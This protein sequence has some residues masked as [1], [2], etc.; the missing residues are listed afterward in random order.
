MLHRRRRGSSLVFSFAAAR[1]LLLFV[2]VCL[3]LQS[4]SADDAPDLTTR[5]S[6]VDTPSPPPAVRGD[7]EPAAVDDPHHKVY[8]RLLERGATADE[9]TSVRGLH[10]T[11]R[12]L[13]AQE[14]LHLRAQRQSQENRDEKSVEEEEG[15]KAAGGGLSPLHAQRKRDAVHA[16]REILHKYGVAPSLTGSK[17]TAPSSLDD[18]V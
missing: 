7:I 9:L 5:R 6:E 12:S 4:A 1:K 10:N 15:V 16:L 3:L 14:E 13:K 17:K 2:A 11:I 18:E 8:K